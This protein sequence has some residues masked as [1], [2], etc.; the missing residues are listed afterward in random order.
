MGHHDY[1]AD[2]PSLRSASQR[3]N[4][5]IQKACDCSSIQSGGRVGISMV[6]SSFAGFGFGAG[7]GLPGFFGLADV[8][9]VAEVAGLIGSTA[10]E[11][12]GDSVG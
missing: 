8:S 9:A 11:L 6:K 2:Q 12:A 1:D 7:P 5:K 10:A 4:E 3:R